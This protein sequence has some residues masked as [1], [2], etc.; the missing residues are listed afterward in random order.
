MSLI[1]NQNEPLLAQPLSPQ[2]V[3][4]TISQ[5]W[6]RALT[7]FATAAG[8]GGILFRQN[9][10]EI[11]HGVMPVNFG[12]EF[13]DIRRYGAL[14]DGSTDDT[15]AITTACSLGYAYFPAGTTVSNS[16]IA[17]FHAAQKWGPGLIQRGANTFA[18]DQ[19]TGHSNTL[20]VAPGAGSDT[21][22]GLGSGQAFL[23]GQ[24]MINA[25][26]TYQPLIGNWTLESAAGFDYNGW[27]FPASVWSANQILVKG[28]SG[29]LPFDPQAGIDG[30][31]GGATTNFGVN[32]NGNNNVYFQ[33][34]WVRKWQSGGAYFGIVG[35][36][37]SQIE[38]GNHVFITQCDNALKG[39]QSR[40]IVGQACMIDQATVG[41]TLISQL[42]H[43]IG[44]G[45]GVTTNGSTKTITSISGTG[46]VVTANFAAGTVPQV[47][48]YCVVV[49]CSQYNGV[50]KV[51]ASSSTSI[52]FNSTATGAVSLTADSV[53]KHDF[54]CAG[55][56]LLLS[57]ATQ[58]GALAQENATGHF[59]NSCVALC[60]P[61]LDIVEKSRFN[62]NN[63]SFLGNLTSDV[64]SRNNSSWADN[65]NEFH[66]NA[67]HDDSLSF[68]NE[69]NFAGSFTVLQRGVPW[70]PVPVDTSTGVQ[71]STV[72]HTFS[73]ALK[74]NAFTFNVKK[75]KV[76]IVG[77]LTGNAGTKN[78]TVN[79]IDPSSVQQP[80]FG[81][82][83][84]AASAPCNFILEGEVTATGA[85]SQ[86]YDAELRLDGGFAG[87]QAQAT[88]SIT[89]TGFT[90]NTD[91]N[92][93]TVV[94]G[95]AD[96]VVISRADIE[97]T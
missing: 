7:S 75:V 46:S 63:S 90:A 66:A 73:G 48:G 95:A 28:P 93:T 20:F 61:G 18:V 3:P 10:I 41:I 91:V 8:L 80:L 89:M 17:G 97:V 69:I 74:Q 9:A 14:V 2:S 56:G 5:R 27:Q 53:V 50:F 6:W 15:A 77:N 92:I 87:Q 64:R 67:A 72:R 31:L 76:K 33:D 79:L 55:V 96:T 37:F 40:V 45:P 11:A 26:V 4:M 68:S 88:R 21:N 54:G 81:F 43:S 59:D 83:I 35:Q 34:F 24:A 29:T 65:S 86:H 30:S 16:N 49:G 25:M 85:A 38:L 62:C 84:P 57:R 39:Q 44:N 36:L 52:S 58:A 23:T 70:L 19:T 1:P 42:T 47:G 71:A 94:N 78:I 22:D 82:T 13:P 60:A 32:L 51:T 12:Y